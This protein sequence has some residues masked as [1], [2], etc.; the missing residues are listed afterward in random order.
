MTLSVRPAAASISA[1]ACA[2]ISAFAL[3]REAQ[4]APA[5]RRVLLALR[6][7]RCQIGQRLVAADVDR[8]E[9]H[10]L[11]ARGLEHVAVEPLL[12]LALGQGGRDEELELGAEQADAVGAGQVERGHVVAQ[13]GIDHQRDAQAVA[14]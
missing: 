13:A 11:V 2:F 6:R 9:D 8:A 3:E 5:H 1:R 4:R 10:R 12:A 7:H 14:A